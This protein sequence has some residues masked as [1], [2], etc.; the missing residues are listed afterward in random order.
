M[1]LPL[2]LELRRGHGCF[3]GRDGYNLADL[4]TSLMSGIAP[5]CVKSRSKIPELALSRNLTH[6]AVANPLTRA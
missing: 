6:F 3:R 4:L 5:G 1:M 2:G